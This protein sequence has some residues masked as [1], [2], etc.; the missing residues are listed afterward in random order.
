VQTELAA[1]I[2]Q[3]EARQATRQR[4]LGAT[5]I[6][7]G[8][9]L[10][11][12]YGVLLVRRIPTSV[13]LKLAGLVA[14]AASVALGMVWLASISR[15]QVAQVA[16]ADRAASEAVSTGA[17]APASQA[18]SLALAPSATGGAKQL[19]EDRFR[20]DEPLGDL[21]AAAPAAAGLAGDARGKRAALDKAASEARLGAAAIPPTAPAAAAQPAA[22]P[23]APPSPAAA[24]PTPA[25]E[26]PPPAPAVL[27]FNPALRTDRVGQVTVRFTM[28]TTPARYRLLVDTLAQGRVGSHEQTL[29]CAPPG[30][31]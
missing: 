6:L 2:A 9:A 14:A 28:P 22:P 15:P 30:R 17:A 21:A 8:V 19:R 16:M 18:E 4:A 7:L 26:P 31:D 3:A 13:P 20:R 12:W 1:R 23:A 10:A 29:V 24:P 27:F 25:P 5:A 11:A